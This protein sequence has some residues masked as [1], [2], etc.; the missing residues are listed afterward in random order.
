MITGV[1]VDLGVPWWVITAIAVV[2]AITAAAVFIGNHRAAVRAVAVT[3]V[4]QAV[5]I[6]VVAPFVMDEDK[7]EPP[8]MTQATSQSA[9]RADRL[10]SPPQASS[11]A[12]LRWGPV[13][14]VPKGMEGAGLYGNPSKTELYAL[15]IRM[16]DGYLMPPHLQPEAEILT[17]IHGTLIVGLGEGFDRERAEVLRAGSVSILPARKPHYFR[18]VGET[19][20][21]VEGIGP[22]D[23]EYVNPADDPDG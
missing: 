22:L 16:P 1:M 11:P 15:R 14:G 9:S 20:V 8:A 3:L 13:P 23:I 21:Q 18:S 6:G 17:V 7:N 12:A 4:L 10:F 2:V 19:I 5:A